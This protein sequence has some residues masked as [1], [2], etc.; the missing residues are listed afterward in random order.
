MYLHKSHNK[1]PRNLYR[2][3]FLIISSFLF[4]LLP[5]IS[6]Q[7]KETNNEIN[8][9]VK[10]T[11][12][13]FWPIGTWMVKNKRVIVTE[14]TTFKGDKSKARFGANIT[15]KGHVIGGVFTAVEIEVITDKPLYATK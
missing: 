12:G 15:A 9:I 4:F 10:K 6:A 11:P 1:V 7:A 14:E 3:F 8:G 13:L 2:A 5:L